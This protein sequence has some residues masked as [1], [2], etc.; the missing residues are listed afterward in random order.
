[1]K[2]IVR[3]KTIT[4]KVGD[5]V[6]YVPKYGD[7]EHGKIKSLNEFDP[8]AVFVVFKCNEEWESY[9]NYTG[10]STKI[11]DLERGWINK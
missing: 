7:L 5:K 4:F 6:T 8:T 1:M 2:E 3:T 10:A 9:Q 11:S